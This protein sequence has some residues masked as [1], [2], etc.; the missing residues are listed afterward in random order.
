MR[1]P[2]DAFFS[3]S[4]DKYHVVRNEEIEGR[5]LTV[6]D[7]AMPI[8]KGSNSLLAYRG[9]LDLKRGAIPIKLYHGQNQ[10][11]APKNQFDHRQPDEIV[12][13]HEIRELP[14]GGYYPT[15]TV[16]EVWDR[17]PEAPEPTAAEWDEVKADKR[18]LP[19]VVH[20]RY[21][22]DC[23]VV[24]LKTDFGDGFFTI[25]F[26][27]GQQLFDHDVG[28]MIG[29]LDAKPLVK[30]G[31]QAPPLSIA[32][33]LDG[34]PRTPADWKGQVVVLDFWGL[35]CGGCRS[36]V[37]RL[38]AIQDRFGTEPVTFISVHNAEKDR[39]KL[40]ARIGEFKTKNKWNFI[41][42][43]DTGTM[44]EDSVTTNAYGIRG[45][46]TLVIIG[47]DGRI[48]YVDPRANASNSASIIAAGL[49]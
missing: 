28:K 31:Q 34:K 20:R 5:S 40:A 4:A 44:L 11:E 24:E 14:N 1:H 46:P 8:A 13:T 26:P 27:A 43:I 41:G 36:S 16:R 30:V 22:W 23:S 10:G 47:T 37:P 35:W 3:Q 39:M 33:W 32:H 45:F 12:T 49:I 38:N 7:V 48:V 19:L 21:T 6:V 2:I 29:A 9:W 25:P 17:D 42:A 15:K 18:R